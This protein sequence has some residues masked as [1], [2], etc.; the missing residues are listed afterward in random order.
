MFSFSCL[1]WKLNLK[2]YFRGFLSV[3]SWSAFCF[4]NYYLSNK[5]R[6]W[7]LIC[8]LISQNTDC[9]TSLC[10]IC[11]E[12]SHRLLFLKLFCFAPK[13]SGQR[14]VYFHVSA[15]CSW[16]SCT[17]GAEPSAWAPICPWHLALCLLC[18]LV[19]LYCC[20]G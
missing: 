6:N 17:A 7:V 19:L 14:S 18:T 3:R 9:L 4:Y 12:G 2:N 16:T 10:S 8:P 5:G 20:A 15:E 1:I 13:G 11:N